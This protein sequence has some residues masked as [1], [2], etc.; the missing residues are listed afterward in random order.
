M[1]D[2]KHANGETETDKL[3]AIPCQASRSANSIEEGVETRSVSSACDNPIQERPA[4]L[5]D[6]DI[7]RTT[8]KPVCGCKPRKDIAEA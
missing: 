3:S 6:D 8:G 5:V 4:S 1:C 7:V 2:T